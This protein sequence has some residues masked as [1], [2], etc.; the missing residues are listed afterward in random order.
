M[1]NTIVGSSGWRQDVTPGNL[2]ETEI[3]KF[4]SKDALDCELD[5]A[6]TKNSGA[7]VEDDDGGEDE[8]KETL[9]KRG[10]R[11]LIR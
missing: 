2:V 4:I 11:R 9:N 1:S 7:I 5:V 3:A 6:D 8:L 10:K